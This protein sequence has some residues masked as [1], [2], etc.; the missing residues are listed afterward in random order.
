MKCELWEIH[1]EQEQLIVGIK[2]GKVTLVFFTL[3]G[4]GAMATP[5]YALK[6]P[7]TTAVSDPFAPVSKS[8]ELII[9]L[10]LLHVSE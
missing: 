8:D 4:P 7:T 10:V 2:V 9:E 3:S 1:T 5:N 6:L